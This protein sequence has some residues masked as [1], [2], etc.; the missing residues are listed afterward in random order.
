MNSSIDDGGRLLKL[1]SHDPPGL[2]TE[3]IEILDGKSIP[4]ENFFKKI[5]LNIIPLLLI[6]AV[7]EIVARLAIHIKGVPFPTPIFT[8]KRFIELAAGNPLLQHTLYTHLLSSLS[9]WVAGFVL[10]AISG[11]IVSLLISRS[12]LWQR[13]VMPMVYILQLIP[14]LAWIPI[15]I[16][17]FGIG[18]KSTIFMIFVIAL[19]PVIINMVAG[20]RGVEGM[21]VKTARMMGANNR[22]IFFH[23]LLPGAIPHLLSGLRVAVASSW[24]VVIAAEMIVGTGSG[25]GYSII[26]ARWSLDYAS[27]FVCIM[28]IC[29][30]GLITENFLFE[31]VERLTIQRWGLVSP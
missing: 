28:V 25:L 17:L 13:I 27:S 19:A 11:I 20:I 16:L 30:I 22:A 24:R 3:G 6:F 29:L 7:W 31:R 18:E 12:A 5:L 15:A 9:R 1:S 2:S 26:Q 23:V 21:Y 10:G 4:K 8:C 14:G